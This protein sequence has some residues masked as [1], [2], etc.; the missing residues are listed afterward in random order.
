MMS[1][2]KINY[3]KIRNYVKG[4]ICEK[5]MIIITKII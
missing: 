2:S 3:F 5:A 4:R 1:Y